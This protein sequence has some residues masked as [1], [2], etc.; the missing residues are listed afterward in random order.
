[1][2]VVADKLDL[3]GIWVRLQLLLTLD[4]QPERLTL[5]MAGRRLVGHA[6]LIH[7]QE[8]EGR[9]LLRGVRLHERLTRMQQMAAK[10]QHGVLLPAR[11]IRTRAVEETR[12]G[13]VALH[14]AVPLQD[15]EVLRLG[16]IILTAPGEVQIHGG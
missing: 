11:Q 15:G 7:T 8:T 3:T 5:T 2:V 1:M 14:Q 16:E 6:R 12:A 13:G 9:H 10:P 4:N